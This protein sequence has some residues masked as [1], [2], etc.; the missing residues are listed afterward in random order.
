MR[1]MSF[2]YFVNCASYPSAIRELRETVI[3]N[4][5]NGMSLTDAFDV[6]VE[7]RQG[8]SFGATTYLV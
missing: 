8:R 5:I 1:L 6:E 4:I 2:N 3:E 7:L